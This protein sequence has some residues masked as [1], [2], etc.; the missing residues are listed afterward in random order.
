MKMCPQHP[1]V[2][3]KAEMETGL[4]TTGWLSGHSPA[5]PGGVSGR[6]VHVPEKS[7]LFQQLVEPLNFLF[8][9]GAAEFQMLDLGGQLDIYLL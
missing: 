2:Q 1:G 3:A 9:L 4:C 8:L 6:L 7:I 5:T